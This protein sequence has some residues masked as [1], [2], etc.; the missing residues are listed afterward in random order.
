MRKTTAVAAVVVGLIG[1]ASMASPAEAAGRFSFTAR[2]G[3]VLGKGA[4]VDLT[5]TSACAPASDGAQ[6]SLA[7]RVAE[8][9]SPSRI[10][11]GYS[12]A[13]I[14]CDGTKQT[15]VLHIFPDA[16]TGPFAP[17]A[18]SAAGELTRYS[19]DG[20]QDITHSNSLTLKAGAAVIPPDVP[21][22][23]YVHVNGASLVAQGA[24]TDVRLGVRCPAGE[25]WY[26]ATDVRQAAADG[27]LV[28]GQPDT[29]SAFVCTG[30]EKPVIIRIFPE[31]GDSP[32][33][34]GVAVFSS[35]AASLSGCTTPVCP[36]P[37]DW[38]DIRITATASSAAV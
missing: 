29:S 20:Y 7:V 6:A 22:A 3:V 25:T 24:A 30:A 27:S 11:T 14:T 31:P 17:G 21:G 4:A 18:F 32:F 36:R 19:V 23:P 35:S 5:Y 8:A 9:T 10:A 38:R 1:L 2:S 28:T 12:S 37:T 33:Q 15:I 13:A 34:T 26:A 16:G